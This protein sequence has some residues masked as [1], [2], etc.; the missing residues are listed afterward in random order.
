MQYSFHKQ[1]NRYKTK[2]LSPEPI[3]DEPRSVR[4]L[5][6]FR[7]FYNMTQQQSSPSGA[8][9]DTQWEDKALT[10][11]K[12]RNMNKT[13]DNKQMGSAKD[14]SLHNSILESEKLIQQLH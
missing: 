11:Y 1:Q 12:S 2:Y 10:L 8:T 5:M 6:S 13:M 4:G 9:R 14:N 3:H 7:N